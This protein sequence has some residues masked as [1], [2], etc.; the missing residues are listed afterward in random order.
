M[1]PANR[2]EIRFVKTCYYDAFV[3]VLCRSDR[4]RARRV[5]R[6]D[7]F[8][9]AVEWARQVQKSTPLGLAGNKDKFPLYYNGLV[10]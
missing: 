7:T 2:L 10:V 5:E 3:L 8:E 9:E 4:A 1:L 6:F